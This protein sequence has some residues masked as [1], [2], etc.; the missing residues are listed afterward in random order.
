MLKDPG[1]R[2]RGG[3][4]IGLASF[5][6][7]VAISQRIAITESISP[8]TKRITP[9]K[10]NSMVRLVVVVSPNGIQRVPNPIRIGIQTK[11]I[12]I[13]EICLPKLKRIQIRNIQRSTCLHYMMIH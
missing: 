8:L 11:R 3:K 9:R 12:V 13:S 7:R 10:G 4:I 2:V 5:A 1:A 6:G